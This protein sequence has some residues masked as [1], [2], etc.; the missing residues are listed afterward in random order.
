M[1][2][3]GM[4]K[5]HLADPAPKAEGGDPVKPIVTTVI[6][7]KDKPKITRQLPADPYLPKE[8]K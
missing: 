2:I 3:T 5:G 6:F 8:S 4:R 1:Q 7:M